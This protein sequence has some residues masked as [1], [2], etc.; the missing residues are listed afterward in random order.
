MNSFLNINGGDEN[1]GEADNGKTHKDHFTEGASLRLISYYMIEGQVGCLTVYYLG[2][3]FEIEVPKGCAVV[4]TKELLE[5]S[6]HAH[7]ARG[8]C[9]S[10]V[11][12]VDGQL[13][14]GASED[15]Q[16]EA[17]QMPLPLLEVFPHWRPGQHVYS[18]PT[19]PRGPAAI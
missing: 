15:E 3:K 11:T 8:R 4:C 2:H 19:A 16:R 1:Q 14:S 5:K 17:L 9:L 7:T 10:I 13:P 6:D 18:S 12:E